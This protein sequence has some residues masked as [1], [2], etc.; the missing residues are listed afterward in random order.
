MTK[1]SSELDLFAFRCYIESKESKLKIDERVN[2][3]SQ[4]VELPWNVLIDTEGNDNSS[5]SELSSCLNS[6]WLATDTDFTLLNSRAKGV[7][8]D[9]II[10]HNR[11]AEKLDIKRQMHVKRGY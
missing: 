11:A 10:D 5:L 8:V 6:N 4:N 3:L 1:L 2:E 7:K 9:A